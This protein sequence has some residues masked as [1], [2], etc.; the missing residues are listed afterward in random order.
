MFVS[1]KK[2]IVITITVRETLSWLA[3]VSFFIINDIDKHFNFNVRSSFY[4]LIQT[5]SKTKKKKTK[6]VRP[7]IV[8]IKRMNGQ[9][10]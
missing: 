7:A 5:V 2:I 8:V 4:L 10:S 6:V 9:K 3:L 1:G